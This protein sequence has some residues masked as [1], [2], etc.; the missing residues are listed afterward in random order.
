M[1]INQGSLKC[2]ETKYQLR[3]YTIFELENIS[4]R[5]FFPRILLGP[6]LK[7]QLIDS[8]AS[9]HSLSS[10]MSLRSNVLILFIIDI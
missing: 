1:K 9:V 6:T 2:N 10:A 5:D 4:L 3:V 7:S 8:K